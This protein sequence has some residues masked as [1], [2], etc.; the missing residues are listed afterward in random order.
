METN[1]KI[2]I[3]IT[4]FDKKLEL[5]GHTLLILLWSIT[6]YIF[7]KLPQIIPI[8]FNLKGEADGYGNKLMLLLLPTLATILHAGLTQLN[9]YPHIFNYMV[10]I[11][12]D[13]AVRQY[14]MATRMIRFVKL[15]MLIIFLIVVVAVYLSINKVANLLG[16]WFLPFTFAIILIPTIYYI[17]QSFKN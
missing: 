1:P 4:A 15:A 8:H 12:E 13:N 11:T 7:F 10:K 5:L 2:K 17:K 3:E 16:F 6:L 14:T 9:K